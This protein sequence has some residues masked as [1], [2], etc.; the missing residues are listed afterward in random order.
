MEP[1]RFT[2]G[3]LVSLVA[4]TV[5][6]FRQ[7]R[8]KFLPSSSPLGDSEKMA[9]KPFFTAGILGQFRIKNLARTGETLSYPPFYERV[10]AGGSRAVPDAAHMTAIT[11]IDVAVFN[12]EAELRAIFHN[13][14]HAT[15]F[16]IVG[17]E[18]VMEGYLRTLSESGQ[19]ITVSFE[20]Q[21]YHL[22]ERFTRNPADV[23]SVD[24]EVR[25]WMQSG[26]Y[27]AQ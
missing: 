24:E 3:E 7:Q 19:W 10:R 9:L 20:E 21:A 11:F 4:E 2:E 13:L 18:R 15:Q 12:G 27:Y 16:S 5:S 17:L 6:W 1:A 14:V 26:R 25:E 23:F 8:E 22:D